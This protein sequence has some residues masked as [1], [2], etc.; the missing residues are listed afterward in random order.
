M[1]TEKVMG[2]LGFAR[3]SQKTASGDATVEAFL[4]KGKVHLLILA[5]D[6]SPGIS[7]KLQFWCEDLGVP[8]Q[9]FGSKTA[10]GLALG[11]SARSAVAILDEGFAQ[12]IRK[13]L[14]DDS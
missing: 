1:S 6:A 12:A 13:A 7:K 14:S 4:K 10:L 3:R 5:D 8:V 11:Q 2:L 9:R